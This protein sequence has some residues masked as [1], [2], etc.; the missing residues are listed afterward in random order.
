MLV[1]LHVRDTLLRTE[2]NDSRPLRASVGRPQMT[3]DD[4]GIEPFA[5]LEAASESILVTDADLERPGP[6]IV[7]A[8][9]SFERMT[10][11]TAR[12]VIGKTPR[13]LQGASTDLLVFRGLRET[14]KSGRRWEGQTVNYRKNESQ[15]VMEWSITPLRDK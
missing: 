10:G 6:I 14:L 5:V 7:Y 3:L 9:P 11:W 1:I 13:I 2:R 12:D 8:N 15:F 4:T